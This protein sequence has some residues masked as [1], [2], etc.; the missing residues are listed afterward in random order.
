MNWKLL[1]GMALAT[2][3][4]AGCNS[5]SRSGSSKGYFGPG[6]T[7]SAAAATSGTGGTTPGGTPGGGGTVGQFSASAA[8]N[9]ARFLH[10]ATVLNDGRVLVAGGTDGQAL[11]TESELFDAQANAWTLLSNLVTTQTDAYMI[12][13]TGAFATVRQYHT[14][15]KMV[16]GNVVIAGGFG[17]E[18]LD[19]N[20]QPVGE[21]LIGAWMFDPLANKFT[22]VADMPENRGWHTAALLSNGNVAVAAGMDQNVAASLQT[23]AQFDT[24]AGTWSTAQMGAK[25]TWGAAM[26]VGNATI[27]VGGVDVT[28]GQ[29]LTITGLPTNRVEVFNAQ[30]NAWQPGNDNADHVFNMGFATDTQ[31][32]GFLAG[33]QGVDQTS[34]QVIILDRIE[35]YDNV[36]QTWSTNAAKLQ[37]PRVV[38]EVAEISTT[39]D[40]LI[41]GG[42]DGAG[43]PL[44]G[45]EL[46]SVLNNFIAGTVSM[47][48]ARV[49]HKA[50][51]L[52]DGRVMVI[53]G[54]DATQ[55]ALGSCE[56]HTR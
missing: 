4:G 7:G 32:K 24:A 12:D 53:G 56:I 17:A 5:G 27:I 20:Q 3:V 25:H 50:V 49:D 9:N 22:K 29:Q 23:S 18:R 51:K 10:T 40:M 11:I 31:G 8:L 30:G 13:A 21:M 16:N 34:G 19:A 46:W 37:T 33:G 39:S 55:A 1:T 47:T 48:D 45:C 2:V 44:A 28:G 36:A 38:P 14:A 43:A 42:V 41:T 6:S 15:T 26:S 35:I 54:Q 52:N